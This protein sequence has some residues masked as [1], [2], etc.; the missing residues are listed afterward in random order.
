MGRSSVRRRFFPQSIV[1]LLLYF[2][3]HAAQ[4]D[5][6]SAI[7]NSHDHIHNVG[8]SH[9]Q[10]L[11]KTLTIARMQG[12]HTTGQ[13]LSKCT[14]ES[15]KNKPNK[16]G[17]W[18]QPVGLRT[19]KYSSGSTHGFKSQV[20]ALVLGVDSKI[21]EDLILGSALGHGHGIMKFN[22]N[23]GK[24]HVYDTFLSLFGTWFGETWYME[25][26]L[27]GGL[28]KYHVAR[29]T[30][31]NNLFVFNHHTGYQL[32]PHLGGGYI[33]SMKEYQ[34]RPYVSADYVYS[35]QAGHLDTG[36]GAPNVYIDQSDSSML[37][38]EAGLNLSK[39]SDYGKF[40]SKLSLQLAAVNK[41]PLKRGLIIASNGTSLEPSKTITTAFSP[42]IEASIVYED[43]WSLSAFWIGEYAYQYTQ[44]EVFVKFRKTF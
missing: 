44:Q 22:L 18:L 35:S 27:L 29:N 43:G 23:A 11:S 15:C 4:T 30:G 37:R 31:T 40:Y 32:C 3:S 8:T 34:L 25:G 38:T 16:T 5:G 14:K 28:Q 24:S 6:L 33:F 26:S 19:N 21:K 42:G 41:R 20:G 9:Q 7:S 13:L 12:A 2:S 39:K 17:V 36:P 1:L 10:A